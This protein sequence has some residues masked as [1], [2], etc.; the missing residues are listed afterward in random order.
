MKY[1]NICLGDMKRICASCDR[2]IENHPE[3]TNEEITNAKLLDQSNSVY[4][5]YWKGIPDKLT[6]NPRNQ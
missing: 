4:C 2:S 5:I 1:F 3:L 6:K